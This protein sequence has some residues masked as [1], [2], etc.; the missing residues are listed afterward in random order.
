MPE[1]HKFINIDPEVIVDAEGSVDTGNVDVSR[2][3]AIKAGLTGALASIFGVREASGEIRRIENPEIVEYGE[4]E[5][6][7]N[8]FE[9]RRLYLKAGKNTEDQLM[10]LVGNTFAELAQIDKSLRLPEM[11]EEGGPGPIGMGRREEDK[12]VW[13]V[14]GFIIKK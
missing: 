10:V 1:G 2:R 13:H 11:P 7:C 6:M 12:S 9:F 4:I 3:T 8:G 14:A 5:Q